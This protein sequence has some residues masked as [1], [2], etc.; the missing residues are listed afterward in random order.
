MR[1]FGAVLKGQVGQSENSLAL[2]SWHTFQGYSN[3]ITEVVVTIAIVLVGCRIIST[4]HITCDLK[5]SP[6]MD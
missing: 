5:R 1:P 6:E 4:I 2:G 3:R